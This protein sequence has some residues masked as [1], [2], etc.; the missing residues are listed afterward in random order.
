VL[1]TPRDA[2]ALRHRLTGWLATRL[3]AARDLA[4]SALASPTR[5]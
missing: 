3:P 5:L 2:D 1:T 4:V